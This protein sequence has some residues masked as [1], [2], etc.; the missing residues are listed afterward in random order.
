VEIHAL[1]TLL[2]V[3]PDERGALGVPAPAPQRSSP[4]ARPRC[5]RDPWGKAKEGYD[6]AVIDIE[7]VVED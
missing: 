5:G 1:H 2:G 3:H 7:V 4:S 6:F